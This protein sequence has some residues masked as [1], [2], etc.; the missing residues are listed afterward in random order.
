MLESTDRH[1]INLIHEG[2]DLVHPES[3]IFGPSE[4][5]V[6]V[7]CTEELLDVELLGSFMVYVD[8]DEELILVHRQP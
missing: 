2:Y 4:C 7:R 8:E 5:N 3:C 6:E 1:Y